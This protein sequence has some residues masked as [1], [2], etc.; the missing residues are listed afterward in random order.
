MKTFLLCD[1]C[2]REFYDD[3]EKMNDLGEVICP[4]CEKDSDLDI[5]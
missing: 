4:D 3:E 1:K 2:K 5:F